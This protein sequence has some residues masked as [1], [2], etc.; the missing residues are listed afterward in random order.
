MFSGKKGISPLM[1]TLL[2]IGFAVALGAIVMNWGRGIEET[3]LQ[4][5]ECRD[6]NVLEL[7]VF[8]QPKV[9]F[10]QISKLGDN[11]VSQNIGKINVD[12][13]LDSHVYVITS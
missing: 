12:A 6:F 8:G 1:A 4:L 2:L 3:S 5:G 7:D 11:T 10:N 9:C 13:D